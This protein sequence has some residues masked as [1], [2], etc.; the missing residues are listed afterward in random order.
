MKA[1]SLLKVGQ[2]LIQGF[3]LGHNGDLYAFGD[4]IVFPPTNNR[5][6]RML[7]AHVA[8]LGMPDL[9]SL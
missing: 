2:G 5:F 6:D 4:I 7:K 9:N 3:P 1:D 8:S